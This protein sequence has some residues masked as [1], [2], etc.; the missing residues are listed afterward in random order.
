MLIGAAMQRGSE[1]PG[2]TVADLYPQILAWA[3]SS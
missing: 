2:K 3:S 1:A